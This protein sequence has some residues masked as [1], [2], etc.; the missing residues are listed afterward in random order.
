ML[1]CRGCGQSVQGSVSCPSHPPG[2]Q[3]EQILHSTYFKLSKCGDV[4]ILNIIQVKFSCFLCRIVLYAKLQ[5][6]GQAVQGSFSC[7]PHH[8]N[9]ESNQLITKFES[10]SAVCFGAFFFVWENAGMVGDKLSRGVYLAPLYLPHGYENIFLLLILLFFKLSEHGDI[11]ILN[12]I[13]VKF[14]FVLPPS[15]PSRAWKINSVGIFEYIL[16]SMLKVYLDVF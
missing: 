11:S 8:H 12:T 9:K 6:W 10:T 7:P 1:S 3:S 4:S 13:Q 15:W 16:A 14:S 5:G 2:Y